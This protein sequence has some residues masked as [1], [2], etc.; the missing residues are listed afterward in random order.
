MT[1]PTETIYQLR[2]FEMDISPI[3]PSLVILRLEAEVDPQA[4]TRHGVGER[5]Q[6]VVDEAQA[7][8]LSKA[9]DRAAKRLAR[10]QPN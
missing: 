7:K 6:C 4:V 10:R 9:F 3:D 5:F 8:S 2:N 1:E